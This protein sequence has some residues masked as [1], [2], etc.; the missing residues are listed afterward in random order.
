MQF[1]HNEMKAVMSLA[2][3]GERGS[4][5]HE[6]A[7]HYQP[8]ASIRT[9][10]LSAEAFRM[11]D[12]GEVDAAVLPIEN[13]LAGSVVEHYDLLWQHEVKAEREIRLRIRHHL[14]GIPGSEIDSIHRVYSHPVALAQCRRFLAEHPHMEAIPFY[15]TAGSVKQ[16]VELRDRHAGGIASMQ[17][18]VTYGG[19]V[20]ASEIEDNAENYT[21]FFVLR[22]PEDIAPD[23]P[24]NKL[25]LAFTVA[26]QPGTLVGA[27][28][29]LATEK[30]NLTKI[31]SRP[32]QGQP[33][34]YVFY[35]DCLV[36]GGDM[37]DRVIAGLRAYC[38]VVRELGRYQAAKE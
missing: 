8:Q 22:R 4:F 26:H 28:E 2:I 32:V 20:L 33:W 1:E 19:S 5:S 38:S 10:T 15:D 36:T 3:Q 17:A 27:L 34:H 29:V 30:A 9:C 37:A 11:L 12:A 21:R 6:A 31:Q 7:L 16:L 24:I 13:S 23:R 25:S 14:I 35:V 18:A